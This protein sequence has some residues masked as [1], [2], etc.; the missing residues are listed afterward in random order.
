[1][2]I[3]SPCHTPNAK[4]AA[5]PPLP[6][7]FKCCIWA[8]LGSFLPESGGFREGRHAGLLCWEHQRQIVGPLAGF[9]P[10][11]DT[12]QLL[13][14]L[15][16]CLRPQLSLGCVDKSPQD[17]LD[18]LAAEELP[19]TKL[20]VL[21]SLWIE[22]GIH[23]KWKPTHLPEQREDSWKVRELALFVRLYSLSFQG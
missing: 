9:S 6:V 22:V 5:N 14:I 3:L 18:T 20:V 8:L 7:G 10:N 1:M 23:F 19:E 16:V 21:S 11:P 13:S 15:H 2:C 4:I 17:P 12:L